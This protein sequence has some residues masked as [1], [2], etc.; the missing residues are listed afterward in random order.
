MSKPVVSLVKYQ[1][2]DASLREAIAIVDGLKNLRPEDNIVIK[3]NL[4]GYDLEYPVPYGAMV[5][6]KLMEALVKLLAEH[7]FNNLTIAE[8]LPNME[9]VTL[10]T[11]EAAGYGKLVERYGV[12]LVDLLEDKFTTKQFVD[13]KLEV[14]N[15]ILEA[16]KIINIPVL[17]THGACQVTLGIKNLKGVLSM[18]SRK[19]CH[20]AEPERDLDLTFNQVIDIL[21][22]ALTIIDGVYSMPK[23]PGPS[24][25]AFRK[26]LLLASLDT[27]AADVVGAE[28]MGWQVKDVG[29]LKVYAE[30]HGR[31]MELSDVEVLG[32]KMVDHV[33]KKRLQNLA[34]WL[35]D[36]TGPKGFAKRGITGLAFR[37]HDNT[38]C[39]YCAG[40]YGL[41]LVALM[42]AFKGEPFPNMEVLSGKRMLAA[43]GFDH[44]LLFGKCPIHANKDNPNIKNA[45]KIKGCPPDLDSFV[46]EMA[47]L[48][49]EMDMKQMDSFRAYMHKKGLQTP[50]LD[51]NDFRID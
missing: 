18:N 19:V 33:E 1:D 29:H 21:P 14:A 22:V 40:S 6:S 38:L 5:T 50:G 9:P 12:K 43:P 37:L 20:S 13:C 48:G 39:T 46:V 44:T 26:N 3:P 11:M 34:D 51:M 2:P 16:D 8:G 36:N 35:P 24:G 45:I 42:S 32:E 28:I 7:G 15:T 47:K 10:Q 27:Y 23:G 4:V 30:R 25:E 41:M 31:S 17:K 49:I